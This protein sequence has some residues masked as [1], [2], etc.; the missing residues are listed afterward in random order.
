MRVAIVADHYYPHLGGVSE[1]VHHLA[2]EL[3]CRGHSVTVVSSR[4]R[5]RN[6]EAFRGQY[7][8]VRIGTGIPIYANGG[9]S[10]LA[11][12]WNLRGQLERTFRE[13]RFDLV[14]VHGALAPT[15]GTLVPFAARRAGLPVVAT[16]HSWFPGSIAFRA[17]RRPLQRLADSHAAN[18]AVSEAVVAATS[19]YITVPWEIVPNGVDLG[20]FAADGRGPAGDPGAGLRL[21]YLHRLEPRNH[22]PTLLAALPA[23]LARYPD[24]VLTVAGEGPW[25]RR[26]QRLA[27]PLGRSVR[28][29]GRVE[30]PAVRYREADIYLC[31]TMRAAFGITLLEAMACGTPMIVADNPGFRAVAGR[32]EAT[33][34]PHDQ[35]AA[36]ADAVVALAGDAERRSCMGAQG[37]V[38][39]A[40]YAWPVVAERILEVYRRAVA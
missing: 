34:V 24:T 18:I 31:P 11:A 39:A 26:Y 4:M 32:G 7:P 37:I 38:T 5:G 40:R 20:R 1:H 21:L 9:L 33:I 22:L 12:G 36:W 30:D 8:V 13:G 35:P 16:F 28:F 23:V 17:F 2:L 10:R 25:R 6:P 15:F 27:R 19:R 14:H 29:V 3:T